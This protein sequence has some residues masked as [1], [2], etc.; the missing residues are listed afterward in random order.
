M[1]TP[2]LLSVGRLLGDGSGGEVHFGEAMAV[3]VEQRGD[4]LRIGRLDDQTG[5][6]LLDHTVDD[7][8]RVEAGSIG[9]FGAGET[10][11]A[12]SVGVFALRQDIGNATQ[13]GDFDARPLCP[14]I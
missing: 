10:E 4:T 3:L 8:R 9:M 1:A 14:E 5:V 2:P 7:L 6:M 12:A 11:D 13:R